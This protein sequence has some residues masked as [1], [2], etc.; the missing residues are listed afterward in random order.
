MTP[1]PNYWEVGAVY[2]YRQLPVRATGRLR[3]YRCM[4]D[5]PAADIDDREGQVSESLQRLHVFRTRVKFRDGFYAF[6]L[7]ELNKRFEGNDFLYTKFLGPHGLIWV[8]K[9]EI[10][11]YTLCKV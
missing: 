8:P 5:I 11:I 10:Y 3:A 9:I 2:E 1:I 7:L 4:Q 6:M